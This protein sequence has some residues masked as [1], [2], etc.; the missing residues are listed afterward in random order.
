GSGRPGGTC[1]P[2]LSSPGRAGGGSPRHARPPRRCRQAPPPGAG[3]AA[4]AGTPPPGTWPR[5]PCNNSCGTPPLKTATKEWPEVS[6]RLYQR[7]GVLLALFRHP[8]AIEARRATHGV[9]G[10][11]TEGVTTLQKGG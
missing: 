4:P 10:P 1:G 3:S 11:D 7:C 2:W 6:N 8:P 5:Q 9:A